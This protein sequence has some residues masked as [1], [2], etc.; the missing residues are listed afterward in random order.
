MSLGAGIHTGSPDTGLPNPPARRFA[1][2]LER[3]GY[4]VDL[5][6][7]DLYYDRAF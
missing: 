3:Q 2:K 7:A 6:V 4:D 1:G 5:A